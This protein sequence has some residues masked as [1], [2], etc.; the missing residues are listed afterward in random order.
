M[1]MT[2]E[3]LLLQQSGRIYCAAFSDE[4][5]FSELAHKAIFWQQR[6][7]FGVDLSSLHAPALEG[8]FGQVLPEH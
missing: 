1:N 2:G 8:Y 7:F 6:N 4:V 5:L 3:S